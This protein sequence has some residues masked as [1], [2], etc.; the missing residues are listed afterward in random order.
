MLFKRR[1][2]RFFSPPVTPVNSNQSY[3]PTDRGRRCAMFFII[4]S[5]GYVEYQPILGNRYRCGR[6]EKW[7]PKK[8]VSFLWSSLAA[9]NSNCSFT[10]TLKKN[11]N[12]SRPSEHSSVRDKN[13]KTFRWD[14]RLQSQNLFMTFV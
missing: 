2:S 5:R 9:I 8:P 11:M 4:M 13:V 6:D 7:Q 12:A 3:G 1:T 14:N 10:C